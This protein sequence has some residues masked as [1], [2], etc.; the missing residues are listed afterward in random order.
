MLMVVDGD[1]FSL[2]K[3]DRCFH[4]LAVAHH[5]DLDDVSDLAPAQGIRKVVEVFDWLVAELHQDIAG[6]ESSFLRGRSGFHVREFD[7]VFHLAE[8]RDR[9]EVRTVATSAG[10]GERLVFHH[11][12]EGGALGRIGEL[13]S[14]A[15]YDI[16]EPRRRGRVDLFPR[17]GR[18]VIV[19]VQSGEEEQDRNVLGD[20]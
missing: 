11:G 15:A 19:R 6:L 14:G 10:A 5:R 3:L 2:L 1:L 12:D 7:A 17:I 4:R 9:T 8:V 13:Q 20:E 16:D 18:L